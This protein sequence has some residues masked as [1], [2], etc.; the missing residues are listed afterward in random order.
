MRDYNDTF[1]ESILRSVEASGASPP[2]AQ[3]FFAEIGSL[4]RGDLAD[5]G[6]LIINAIGELAGRDA[7]ATQEGAKLHAR[8]RRAFG[9]ALG[10][11]TA[12]SE[13][14][15]VTNAQRAEILAA[16]AMGVWITSRVK[17]RAAADACDAV[18]VQINSWTT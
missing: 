17:P 8:Y 14:Q 1:I 7:A 9:N 4:F 2:D 13:G 10:A 18:V 16:V 5:R 11:S 12:R 3:R 15:R 6:C